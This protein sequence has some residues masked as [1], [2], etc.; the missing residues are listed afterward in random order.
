MGRDRARIK[1]LNYLPEYVTLTS[2]NRG[3]YILILPHT[4][5]TTYHTNNLSSVSVCSIPYTILW[6]VWQISCHFDDPQ[7]NLHWKVW[8]RIGLIV[9]QIWKMSW[10]F[11][12]ASET[13]NSSKFSKHVLTL[14]TTWNFLHFAAQN[15][16]Q[17]GGDDKDSENRAAWKRL[18]LDSSLTQGY[19]VCHAEITLTPPL[20]TRLWKKWLPS[21]QQGYVL[22]NI[23]PNPACSY[24]K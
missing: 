13:L 21:P 9:V 3:F 17:S 2:T 11:L 10:T 1:L 20:H 4:E 14:K 24:I 7:G 23:H 19:L 5:S 22:E 6:I 8:A 16:E 15:I 12:M 18:N